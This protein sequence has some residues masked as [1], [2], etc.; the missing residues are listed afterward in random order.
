M[1]RRLLLLGCGTVASAVALTLTVPSGQTLS[2]WWLLLA[3]LVPFVLATET[4][5]HI[6]PT[7]FARWRLA[8]LGGVATFAVFF[9]VF[10][11]KMFARVLANDFAGFYSLM[12]VLTP[13]LI[14]GIALA[15]RL[16]GGAGSSVRRIAYGSILVMLSGVED[17]LFWVWR[18]SPIPARWDWADH[19]TVVLGHVASRTEAYIFIGVHLAA[20]AAVLLAPPRARLAR[21]H[22][23]PS[24]RTAAGALR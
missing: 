22:T 7:W 2:S 1:S 15:Y 6:D 18:G 16:G 11:P 17:L 21:V 23:E 5:A 13:L 24:T 4:I 14:L 9:C 20:A 12:R 10:T 19:I 8:E 3:Y